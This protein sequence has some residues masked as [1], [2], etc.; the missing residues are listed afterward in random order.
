VNTGFLLVDIALLEACR[1][2]FHRRLRVYHEWKQKNVTHTQADDFRAPQIVLDAG[3]RA[4]FHFFVPK[5]CL[6][7]SA[8]TNTVFDVF[9]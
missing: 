6:F 9:V 8:N 4:S 7:G 3:A 1:G 2:E 5:L